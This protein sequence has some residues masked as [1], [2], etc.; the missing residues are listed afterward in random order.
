VLRR[1]GK[2]QVPAV[3]RV[4]ELTFDTSR[5]ELRI[6]P[7]KAIFLT[8]LESRLFRYLMINAGHVL[9]SDAIIT[10]VWGPE[11]GDRDMLR[12][13]VSRLRRKI[14]PDPAKPT[15]IENVPGFGYGLVL[16]SK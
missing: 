1:T 3:L 8:P 16:R 4:G 10:H 2:T 13:L 15:Y 11:G 9:T 7:D 12:Q 6:G 5:R 14:E